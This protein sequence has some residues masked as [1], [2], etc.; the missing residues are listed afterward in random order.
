MGKG[1]FAFVDGLSGLFGAVGTASKDTNC[2]VLRDAKIQSI[3]RSLLAVVKSI[4]KSPPGSEDVVLIVDG[5]DFFLAATDTNTESVLDMIRELREVRV[6]HSPADYSPD[7]DTKA[8]LFSY[9]HLECAY[10]SHLRFRRRSAYTVHHYA[11]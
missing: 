6:A 7:D 1:E 3:E 8:N 9:V 2:T 5:L 4:T 10:P 11:S